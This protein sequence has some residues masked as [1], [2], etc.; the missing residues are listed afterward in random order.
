MRLGERGAIFWGCG[1]ADDEHTSQSDAP[2]TACAH[3][4]VEGVD[5]SDGQGTIDWG[6]AHAAGIDFAVIKATQGTY[7]HA[8]DVPRQLERRKGGG[9]VR[10]AY[11]F[12][13]PTEDGVAQANRFL[14]VVGEL[15]AGDLPPMLDLECPDGDTACLGWAGGTGRAPGAR[16]REQPRSERS[17][18][19]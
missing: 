10:G 7:K 5:V 18:L 6:T 8:G 12:F 4:T 19:F 11:H 16:G 9:I 13:D 15:G 3:A 1:S 14:S 2:I 17:G